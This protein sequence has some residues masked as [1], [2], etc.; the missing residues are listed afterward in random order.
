MFRYR[1]PQA[2]VTQSP[3][4]ATFNMDPTH[5]SA[6]SALGVPF[7]GA[8]TSIAGTW[9]T[10]QDQDR[11]ELLGRHYADREALCTGFISETSRV[12]FDVSP[13]RVNRVYNLVPLHSFYG[14]R[15]FG[16]CETVLASAEK[17]VKHAIAEY[18]RPTMAA[19]AIQAMLFGPKGLEP[20]QPLA[21]FG[22]VYREELRVLSESASVGSHKHRT[23][24]K[25]PPM[26]VKA[27]I[28]AVYT[29]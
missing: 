5:T 9:L 21:D 26:A 12:A 3:L 2:C 16:S 18:A 11:R 13:T 7:V 25:R 14:R 6:L 10:R 28:S 1:R 29:P 20:P 24:K 17:V 19:A 27:T 4:V 8:L 15:R 23:D 22:R